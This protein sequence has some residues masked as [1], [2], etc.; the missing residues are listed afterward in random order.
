GGLDRR[1]DRSRPLH[2]GEARGR[3]VVGE[4]AGLCVEIR[5]ELLR[6]GED[7]L[8]PY[9]LDQ[10]APLLAPEAELGGAR[11]H[12]A[13]RRHAEARQTELPNGQEE[14][15]LHATLRALRRRVEGA[16][17]LDRIAR[18]LEPHWPLVAGGEDVEEAPPHGEVARILDERHA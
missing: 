6:A 14:H 7:E 9:R 2:P 5:K 3:Q 18:E 8:A 1:L 15:V 17:T 13:R 4:R 12:Q 10:V 11:V 16:E